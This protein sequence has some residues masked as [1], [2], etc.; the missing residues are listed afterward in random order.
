[1]ILY[2]LLGFN[3]SFEWNALMCVEI[4][5][6]HKKN[7]SDGKVFFRIVGPDHS[8]VHGFTFYISK[9]RK[10]FGKSKTS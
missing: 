8:I 2:F 3:L 9:A 4:L 1:M 7:E 10:L 5:S 6:I